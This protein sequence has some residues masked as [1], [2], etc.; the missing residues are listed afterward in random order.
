MDA[1]Q[2]SRV[3]A[4]FEAA[5]ERPPGERSA[6]VAA[7][8][9]DHALRA[10]VL[11]LLAADAGTI[12]G[13]TEV[14]QAAPDLLAGLGSAADSDERATFVG[15]RVGPWKL[16]RELGRGGMGAVY[17]AERV[18][19]DFRQLAA[20]KLVRSSWEA[21]ELQ[22]RFRSERR[23][24]ASLDHPNI[25]RLV[26]GGETPDGKPYLAMEYVD[27]QPLCVHCDARR[28]AVADRLRLFLAVCAAVAHAHRSLV[29]HRDL[30]PS[31]VLVGADG[32][33]KLLDFGIAR[34]LETDAPLTGSAMRVFTPEYAAPEQVRGDPLTTSVDVYALGVMLFELLTGRR[35]YRLS[36]TT[37][38]MI[39]RAIL[40]EE[41]QRP[42]QAAVSGDA[43]SSP[44]AHAR[45]SEPHQLGASL[46]GDLDAIVL[47]ALRKEPQ[48]RYVSVEALANDVRRYLQRQPV[49]ARRGNWRY[50]GVRFMQRHW[51]AVALGS[52]ALACILAGLGVALWQAE[53]A[54][55]QELVAQNEA[56]KARAVS[57]FLTGVFK[58]AEPGSSDGRDPRASELLRHAA[59][60]VGA[61]S[62]LAPTSR[63]S[64]LMA[65][66]SAYLTMDDH[67]RGLVLMRSAREAALRGDDARLRV[68][69]QLELARALDSDGQ[70]KAALQELEQAQAFVAGD[71]LSD[72]ALR[73]RFGYLIAIVYNNLDRSADALPHLDRAYREAVATDGLGSAAVG[74]FVDLY[75]SLLVSVHRND[76]AIALTG[77][78]YEASRQR[79]DLPLLER[80]NFAAAYGLSLL[81]ADRAADAERAYREALALDEQLYGVGNL[82][83]D[84]SMNN[85][86]A[87][88]RNQRKFAEAAEFGARVLALRKAHLPADAAAIARSLA[89][90]G[91]IR[92]SAGD[93]DG[94][95][96]LLRES[97][98]IFDKRGEDDRASAITAHLNLVR[99]LE[100][101][102][103]YDE[104]LQVMAHVL[105]HTRR[106]SS[107]YAGAGG[108]EVR[109]MHARLLARAEPQG[110]DCS[111]IAQVL[112]VAP[113][114]EAV[115]IEAHVLAADC[116]RR[117]GR[118]QPAQMHLAA[119]NAAKLS[120]DR[121]STYAR[122]RLDALGGAR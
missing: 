8:C 46:R 118:M 3:R 66:G 95:V 121:L 14:A 76:E 2:W 44:L 55:Q 53:R 120:P 51:L 64:M 119:V 23:I 19:G 122:E 97:V 49:A 67:P 104:A 24:L 71:P 81:R 103:N 38:A 56:R 18:D 39:E 15:A 48:Q 68:E 82:A 47:K 36:A 73:R 31:N 10:E 22:R 20:I 5:L 96:P 92:R 84:I 41:A 12:D 91:D 45:A 57:E 113:A 114:G 98:A 105:P 4:M 80:S 87:A 77:A 85:V 25:A 1:G 102:G 69:T 107:Q 88:L 74:K 9:A 27:G 59:D 43:L 6:F 99:A 11:A 62:D 90:L 21:G 42:S 89:M 33:V 30:K 106:S 40:A 110:K 100:G 101:A 116:E 65:I 94:A 16:E 63:A 111:A 83:T 75:S 93:F 79:P 109:L 35:P 86:T 115:A 108:A 34:L 112:E 32:E 52:S 70:S 7:T 28:L 37:P 117:N 13:A 54:R 60:K 78:N 58:A 61:Q 72:A 29:V 26:D 17:L 50:R